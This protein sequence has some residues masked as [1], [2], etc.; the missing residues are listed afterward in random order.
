MYMYSVTLLGHANIRFVWLCSCPGPY[1]RVHVSVFVDKCAR[2]W[3]KSASWYRRNREKQ[4][5]REWNCVH[6]FTTSRI[7]ATHCSSDVRWHAAPVTVEWIHHSAKR[8]KIFLEYWLLSFEF[9]DVENSRRQLDLIRTIYTDCTSPNSKKE[10]KSIFSLHN[11][12][13]FHGL[14]T[15][16]ELSV[17][18][19][20]LVRD[21]H[22]NH[23]CWVFVCIWNFE[24]RFSKW[25]ARI[26]RFQWMWIQLSSQSINISLVKLSCGNYNR[27]VEKQEMNRWSSN[28]H[29]EGYETDSRCTE[30]V[31]MDSCTWA[32][33]LR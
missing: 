21:C 1:V 8:N 4:R 29:I 30:D 28:G 22:E 23:V 32:S 11:S 26:V 24:S 7:M 18:V 25:I 19:E 16:V 13:L 33:S 9:N 2:G 31:F 17:R 3:S 5:Q 20:W 14:R 12:E 6:V 10:I 15:K 27:E